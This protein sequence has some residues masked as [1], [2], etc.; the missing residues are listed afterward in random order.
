LRTRRSTNWAI[1]PKEGQ[2]IVAKRFFGKR[3]WK[4]A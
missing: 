1:P 3:F 4:R 2:I